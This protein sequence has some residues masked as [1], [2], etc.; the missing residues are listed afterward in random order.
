MDQS[1]MKVAY[2]GLGAMGR[3]MAA[4]LA[5]AFPTKVW[6]RTSAVA[7]DHAA[8]HGTSAVT[9]LADLADVQVVCSCLPTDVE[10]AQIVGQ[11][12]PELAR[13][14][15]W[16]DHTSG[17]PVGSQR[18]AES[19]AE[20]GVTYLDAPVSGG[21]AGAEAGTLT[22]MIG[23]S[24]EAIDEVRPVLDAVAANVVRVGDVGAGMAVKAINQALLATSLQAAAEGLTVLARY[25]VSASTAL[26]VINGAT[27]R[28]FVTE[29]LMSRA[30][31]REFPLTFALGLLNKDVRLAGQLIA[32][33]GVA[34]PVLE[35]ARQLTAEV[36][37]IVG[38]QA[39]HVEAVRLAEQRAGVELQ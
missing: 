6:N 37:E 21:T 1:T 32:E 12:G 34:A 19:L 36:T 5:R 7:D 18:I 14:T 22:V 11:L 38:E 9:D 28:S 17:D 35:L 33:L 8:Q 27:G 10:V 4:N 3:P 39:D 16:L 2:L 15:V 24:Q 26:D 23:G 25:G 20:H 30:T 13:G 29:N 31:S